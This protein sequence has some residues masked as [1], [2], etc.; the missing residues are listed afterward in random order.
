MKRMQW[1]WLAMA[2]YLSLAAPSRSQM[3]MDFFKKPNITDI[4]KPVV[5][6]GSMYETQKTDPANALK[7]PME[8]T[9]VGKELVDGKDAY[10]LEFG[11]V[12]DRSGTMLYAKMLVTREDFQ[13]HKMVVQRPGQPAMEMPI[14][15]GDAQKR[16]Q[17]ELDKWHSV[18]MESITVPAGTFS[19]QHWK[20]DQGVGDVWIS[21]KVSPFGMIKYVSPGETMTL[22]RVITDAKDRITGPVQQF[23]PQALRQQMMERMQQQQQAPK[24]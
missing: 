6:A 18:G 16:Q 1:L 17:D 12:D 4:F 24:P 20:K 10:W 22:T 2:T 13:F 11:H 15:P 14:R 23:D 19:C 3:R 5:G 9:I 8:M 21:D 7:Q